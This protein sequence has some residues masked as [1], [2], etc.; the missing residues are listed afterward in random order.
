MVNGMDTAVA[1]AKSCDFANF[2]TKNI[3]FLYETRHYMLNASFTTARL[4]GR[5][6]IPTSPGQQRHKNVAILTVDLSAGW[7]ALRP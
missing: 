6:A 3:I 1:F 4:K 7:A 2:P 5:T